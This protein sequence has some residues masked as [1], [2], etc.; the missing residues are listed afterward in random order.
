MLN[1]KKLGLSAALSILSPLAAEALEFNGY[2][3]SG[4]GGATSGG[5][6]SCF[7]LPGAPTKYRLGNECEQYAEFGVRHDL[8]TLDDGSVLS[9][10]GMAAL[11]NQYGH[12]PKFS[13]DYGYAR[14][15]QA[16]AEW[17]KVPQLNNGSLWAGRRFYK[18]NDIHISDF[19]YWDQSGTGAGIEDF[20]LGGLKYSYAFSRKDNVFQK[21]YT[22]RHDFNIGGINTN[23]G[24]ELEFGVSYI[25][26]PDRGDT[27]SG[28]AVTVQHRQSD[29]LGGKAN[30]VAIQHGQ[31]PG[32]SLGYTGNVELERSNRSWRALDYFDWQI[33]PRFGGQFQVV[34]QRDYR[35]GGEKQDWVSVGV[36][37]VYA[38]SDQLKLIAEIGHDQIDAADGTR[39]LSKFT[40]APTWSPK[41][42]GFW[43]RPEIRLYYTYAKWNRAAQQAANEMDEGSALS[44][45]GAFNSSRHG[46]NF[47]VQV[48]YW[49]E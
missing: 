32:T 24:G 42:S 36:R 22:N 28:W 46:S 25:E 20:E 31:G 3:R 1:S 23:P 16:Y 18:R 47:G 10:E 27:H 49:W 43:D 21:D 34:A 41:G 6:Q 37:P 45:T 38:I 35:D 7:Q 11:Q 44:S 48:E 5:T 2:L 19:Y 33:T 17:S 39:K 15:V 29:V 40:V 12:T 9:V 14:I 4:I 26:D 30:T 13:D 8:A